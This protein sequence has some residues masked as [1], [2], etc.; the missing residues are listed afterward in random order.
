MRKNKLEGVIGYVPQDD[1]LIEDLILFFENLLFLQ[2]VQ[3]FNDKKK[4]EIK[5]D[6]SIKTLSNPWAFLKKT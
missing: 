2:H 3:C 4:D 5:K 6:L 1:V